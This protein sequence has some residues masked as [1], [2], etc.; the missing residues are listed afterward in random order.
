MKT[1]RAEQ[2]KNYRD[3]ETKKSE[4]VQGA[5]AERWNCDI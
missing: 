4:T 3:Y 5:S 1:N 2:K